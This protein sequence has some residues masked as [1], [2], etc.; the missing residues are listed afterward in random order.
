MSA[1]TSA[2]GD[3]E[4]QP[5]LA[6]TTSPVD[7]DQGESLDRTTW[8][9]RL[10]WYIRNSSAFEYRGIEP[11]AVEDRTDTCYINALSFWTSMNFSILP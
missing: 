2:T 1:T 6:A 3:V 11:V 9:R 10:I 8:T 5:Q 7:E 4:K